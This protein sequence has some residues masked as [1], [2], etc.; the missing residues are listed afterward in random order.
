MRNLD[1]EIQV[2]NIGDWVS[3]W[4]YG[5]QHYGAAG[6]AVNDM[7]KTVDTIRDDP[8]AYCVLMGDC[9]DF[10]NFSDKRFDIKQIAKQ[11]HADLDDLPR[12]TADAFIEMHRPIAKKII[13]LVPGN[14]DE[15]IRSHYAQDIGRHIAA[16]LDVP[17]LACMSYLRIRI[18]ETGRPKHRSY[19]IKGVV[20][21]AEK[22]AVTTGGKF[23]AAQRIADYFVDID[24]FAQAHTHEYMAHQGVGLGV[25][26]TFNHGKSPRT[27]ERPFFVL[28]TG[29]YLK[30][31]NDGPAGY[32][33]RKGY[34][35]GVLGSPRLMVRVHRTNQRDMK[36]MRAL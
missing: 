14:H 7:Q 36:E 18:V 15:K 31:F 12:S 11:F 24:F 17:Y 25:T 28:L 4:F 22:G 30:T 16:C 19:M 13:G 26:G 21:H 1:W 33:E 29:G 20:S 9:C 5:D 3:I 27:D 23:A 35:P 8:N 32:G 6:C 10:V 2:E 34:R